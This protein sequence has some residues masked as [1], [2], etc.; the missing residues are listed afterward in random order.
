MDKEMFMDDTNSWM[1]PLPFRSPQRRLPNNREQAFRRLNSMPHP[2][3]KTGVENSFC[4]LHAKGLQSQPGWISST[5]A[6]GRRTMVLTYIWRVSPSKAK[7][8]QSCFWLQCSTSQHLPE[9]CATYRPGFEQ[10][11][12]RSLAAFLKRVSGCDSRHW[13]HVSQLCCQRRPPRLSS[14]P[15]VQRQRT[16]QGDCRVQDESPCIR[17]QPISGSSHLW[18]LL[19][20]ATWS[21][22]IWH[23]CKA[24]CR[25]WLLR[26]CRP[27]VS[28]INCW[29][30]RPA[31][32]GTRDACRL[33]LA[34]S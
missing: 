17:K 28:P 27:Q 13:A 3:K 24:L 20:S 19:S 34:A 8:D 12:T 33:Q 32:K 2:R 26:Q 15:I 9:W 29:S 25:A 18:P 30:Y 7:S 31:E 1:T 21:R 14:V 11:S 16:Q 23:G 10:W 6:R 4:E 5:A 22:R